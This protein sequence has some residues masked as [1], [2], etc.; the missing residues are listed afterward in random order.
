[1]AAAPPPPPG[2]GI[3]LTEAPTNRRDDP[4][5]LT[6]IVDHVKPGTTFTR[7]LEA[8]NGD[9]TAFS[10]KF[11]VRAASLQ[12]GG[13]VID[14]K[15]PGEI[16]D[17]ASITPATGTV[18]P[19]GAVPA[20]LTMAVPASATAGEYY[21]AAIVEKPPPPGQGARLASRA[22]IAIYLSVGAG[23][24]PKSD[25]QVT[26]LTAS[27]DASGAA[28][29][30]AQVKNTGGRALSIAGDLR[31]S[32]GPGGLN[33][34]PF[35][36]KLGTVIG[37]GQSEPVTVLL[38]KDL[39]A[40]PWHAT[41]KLRSGRIER[42]SEGTITFPAA[43]SG[44]PVKAKLV[45]DKKGLPWPAVIGGLVGLLALGLILLFFFKRRSRPEDKRD[46]LIDVP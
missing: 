26:T 14:D 37:I 40:G 35:P 32:S 30:S 7:K 46:E 8:T 16:T 3:R 41:L 5:A 1:V 33:A 43:G 6:T 36:A 29:V 18:R 19:G 17:W 28:V 11:Y 21:G 31:L 27:R 15:N 42:T 12:G 2:V 44:A 25:F 34:G 10:V 9:K 45:E 4:R 22:A 20:T 39:P 24:E 38:S 23:G 13:F